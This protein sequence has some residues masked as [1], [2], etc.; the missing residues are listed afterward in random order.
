M[1]RIHVEKNNPAMHLYRHLGF[2]KI[3]DQGVIT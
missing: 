3:E 1:V 2:E